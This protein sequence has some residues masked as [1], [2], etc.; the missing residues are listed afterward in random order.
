MFLLTFFLLACSYKWQLNP[1]TIK[2]SSYPI[3][4]FI[5]PLPFGFTSGGNYQVNLL[6][7]LLALVR[8]IIIMFLH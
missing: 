7:N 6:N 2:I 3:N 5:D 1:V 4:Q 8:L